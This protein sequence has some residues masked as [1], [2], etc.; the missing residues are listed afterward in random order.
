MITWRC[1]R[2]QIAQ[3]LTFVFYAEERHDMIL[4]DT[5]RYGRLTYAE[6]RT[7]WPA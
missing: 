6:K 2:E 7:R 3:C 1:T 5:I 4:Y